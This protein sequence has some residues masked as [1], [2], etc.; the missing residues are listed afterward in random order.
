MN[1][2]NLWDIQDMDISSFGEIPTYYNEENYPLK[3]VIKGKEAKTVANVLNN[4]GNRLKDGRD[5]LVVGP[6]V[7]ASS[8][9]VRGEFL[10]GKEQAEKAALD[11]VLVVKNDAAMET[12]QEVL[13]QKIPKA[14]VAAQ[15]RP[16]LSELMRRANEN[17]VARDRVMSMLAEDGAGRRLR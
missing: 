13:E 16:G 2:R 12:N 8:Q 3:E 10:T 6:K 5:N 14:G 4:S 9:P 17:P 7:G 11:S 15:K 1:R